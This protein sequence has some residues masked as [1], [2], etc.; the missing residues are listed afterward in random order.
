MGFLEVFCHL[1]LINKA[2]LIKKT[3]IL[4]IFQ[5]NINLAHEKRFTI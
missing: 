1:L 5:S 2:Y 3:E 4:K